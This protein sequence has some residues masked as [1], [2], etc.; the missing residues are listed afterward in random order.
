M[1][2]TGCCKPRYCGVSS[3]HSLIFQLIADGAVKSSLVDTVI[4]EMV[5]S[6]IGA[7]ENRKENNRF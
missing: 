3:T 6:C 7:Y 4:F 1:M 2:E 5:V